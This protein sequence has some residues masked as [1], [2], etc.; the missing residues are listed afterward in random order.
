MKIDVDKIREAHKVTD[1]VLGKMYCCKCGETEPKSAFYPMTCSTWEPSFL[2][3]NDCE[4][5]QR[6]E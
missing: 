1:A 5:K 6:G 2:I 3:C 4:K